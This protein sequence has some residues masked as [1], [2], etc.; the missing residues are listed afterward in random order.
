LRH[1]LEQKPT[2]EARRRMQH[3]LEKIGQQPPADETLRLLRTLQVLENSGTEGRRLLR[4]LASG[5]DQTWL[6]REAKAALTRLNRR[7]P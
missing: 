2:L 6:T 1:A 3:L 5:A 4:E 7:A